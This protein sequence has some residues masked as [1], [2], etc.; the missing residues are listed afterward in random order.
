LGVVGGGVTGGL[1]VRVTVAVPVPAEFV[2][3]TWIL[4]VLATDGLPEI[5]PDEAFTFSPPGRPVAP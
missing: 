2:A 5:K 4:K 3:E 1:T